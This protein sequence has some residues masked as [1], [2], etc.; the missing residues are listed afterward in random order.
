MDW[1]FRK[2]LNN[3]VLIEPYKGTTGT[4][5]YQFGEPYPAKCLITSPGL[6]GGGLK[7]VNAITG[8]DVSTTQG[9]IFDSTVNLHLKDRIHVE[10]LVLPIKQ[11]KPFYTDTGLIDYWE[12]D[13]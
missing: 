4:G 10:D 8:E 3:S 7:L 13:I 6:T 12:V 1:G 2:W 5:D 9:L 11:L